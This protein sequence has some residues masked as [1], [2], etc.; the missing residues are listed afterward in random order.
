M[1][2][3]TMKSE[4][5]LEAM[6]KSYE[7]DYGEGQKL[8]PPRVAF[9]Y[10]W[11]NEAEVKCLKLDPDWD[12]HL[13][14]LKRGF[15]KLYSCVATGAFFLKFR[16]ESGVERFFWI[17]LAALYFN[18]SSKRIEELPPSGWPSAS[19]LVYVANLSFDSICSQGFCW[20]LLK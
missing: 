7:G 16:G 8:S 9:K 5:L 12:L 10:I 6:S 2:P 20:R 15:F 4:D 1:D 17:P 14:P 19:L 11:D 18:D 3:K 13:E